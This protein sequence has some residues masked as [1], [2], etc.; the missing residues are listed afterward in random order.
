MAKV[1]LLFIQFLISVSLQFHFQNEKK[2][3]NY[4]KTPLQK[5]LS[6]QPSIRKAKSE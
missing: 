4:K 1:S 5:E 2:P 6:A 3:L